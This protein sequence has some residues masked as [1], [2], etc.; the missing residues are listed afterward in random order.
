ME[1]L[2]NGR[3]YLAMNQLKKKLDVN[4]LTMVPKHLIYRNIVK[5]FL[6]YYYYHHYFSYEILRGFRHCLHNA[7]QMLFRNYDI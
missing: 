6:N 7:A 5:D 1:N 4:K 3:E 2:E